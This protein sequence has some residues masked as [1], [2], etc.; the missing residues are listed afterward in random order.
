MS[1]IK[2]WPIT[3]NRTITENRI[4][5]LSGRASVSPRTDREHEFYILECPDWV[6]IVPLTD[7]GQVVMVRQFRHGN[8]EITL[9]IPGG[10]V[11]PEDA[12]P[13]EAAAREML[14]E[15]GYRAGRV[16]RLGDIAPN[17]AILNNRCHSFLATGLELVGDPVMDGA[18]DIEV[19]TVPLAEVPGLIAGGEI[20]HA[21]VV[22][23]FTYMLGLTVA[24]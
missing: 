5:R 11:D 18:E 9:E 4:F 21:L 24:E 22:V 7:D 3:G 8:R 14:E 20:S 10:M 1:K 2:Q 23:A 19:V 16:E 6:N 13:A 17:P 12:S 15:T